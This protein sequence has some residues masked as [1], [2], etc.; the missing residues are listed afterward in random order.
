MIRSDKLDTFKKL[1]N[2]VS[3][4]DQCVQV[5]ADEPELDGINDTN[6]QFQVDG[7]AIDDIDAQAQVEYAKKA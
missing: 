1:D 3:K 5:G 7:D 6:T 2:Q 4:Y